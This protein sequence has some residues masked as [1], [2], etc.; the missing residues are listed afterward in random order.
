M[1]LIAGTKLYGFTV[2]RVRD[3]EELNGTLIEMTH[4]KTGAQLCWMDNGE[5]NMLFSVIFKTLPENNTGVFHILEHSVLCGSEQYPVREPFVELLKSSMNTFLN[6]MT[7]ADKTVYPVS[8]RNKKDFLNLTAV[9]L[10]A[11]FA[12][13]LVK[14][15][16]IFYQEGW[17]IESDKEEFYYNGV[18]LNEMKGEMS[19]IDAVVEQGMN[20]LL[21]P[22]TCYRFHSGGE[23]EEITN[24]TYE[25]FVETYRRFYHPSNARFFLDG[26]I[27]LDEMLTMI[28]SYLEKGEC[29][30][31]RH[32]LSMQK[33]VSGEGIQYY[34]VSDEKGENQAVLSLGK[35][36]G[37]WEQRDRVTAVRVL[38]DVLAGSNEAPLKRALLSSGLAADAEMSVADGIA[39][40]YLLLEVRNI[41]DADSNRIRRIIRKTVEKLISDGLN[42]DAIEASISCMEFRSRQIPEPQG[43]YRAAAAL[44]SWLYGGDPM[45]YLAFE[46]VSGIL[47]KMAEEGGFETLLR[48]LL[49]EEEGLVILHTLPSAVLGKEQRR[50]EEENLH[51]KLSGL[52][53]A[54]RNELIQQNK[55]LAEWQNTPD[56]PAQ[57]SSLPVLPVSEVNDTPQ[58]TETI[59]KQEN[60]VTLLYHPVNTHG[61]VNLS[62]YFPLTNFSL[63][64]L[65]MLS[66]LPSVFGELPTERHRTEELQRLIKTY[67]G[68][69]SFGLEAFGRD[70]RIDRCK[71]CFTV[72]AGILSENFE[73]AQVLLNEILTETKFDCRDNIREIVKQTDEEACQISVTSGHTLGGLAVKA[74]YTAQDAVNEATDGYTFISFIHRFARNFDSMYGDFLSLVGRFSNENFCKAG[75]TVSITSSNEVSV[76]ELLS[77]LPEGEM[78]PEYAVYSVQLPKKM[79]ICIPAQ[80]AYAVKGYHLSCMGN[81][82]DGSMCVAGNILS[83]DY[84]W[85]KVR[86]QGGAYGTGFSIGRDGSMLSYSYRDPSPAGSLQT[87]DA[88]AEFLKEFCDRDEDPEQFIIASAA[89]TE[90]LRTPAGQGLEADELWFS[91]ITEEDRKRMHRQIL[92]TDCRRLNDFCPALKKMSEEG[93]ICVLGKEGV[94]K[95]FGNLTICGFSDM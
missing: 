7:Y 39:Q 26:N 61:I 36:I 74:H 49:L 2:K 45:L 29:S 81:E 37:T 8:S 60:G 92:N 79:G 13:L 40:P 73:T 1:H 54:E 58:H 17:H 30:H 52:T 68:Q 56:T 94:L 9:Y 22:D 63:P 3:S 4:D 50:A 34:E 88:M 14:N 20:R 62:L 46:G 51:T 78:L 27:P 41:N 57:R 18:V 93:C 33:P 47:R 71:P 64:E 83:L 85:N 69:L 25:Q 75:L 15:P 28:D 72:H 95:A 12:P 32:E 21:F 76:S 91:G 90:P 84:L 66:L 5:V 82:Y 23:P 31:V 77:M 86:V 55:E 67:I 38:C 11:V 16:N 6:A 80:T 42:R 43:L 89:G 87:F 35:I 48:E 59:V 70:D 65:T 10:D 53:D 19:G 44:G 24:L